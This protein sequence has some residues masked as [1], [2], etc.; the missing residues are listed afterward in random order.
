MPSSPDVVLFLATRCLYRGMWGKGVH[1]TKHQPDPQTDQ[2]SWWPAVVP[3]LT[4]RCLH[5]GWGWRVSGG[6]WG[7]RSIRGIGGLDMKNADGLLQSTLENSRW[8]IA[9]NRT[10]AQV[11]GT[12]VHTTLGHLMPLP[13]DIAGAYG[14]D[15]GMGYIWQNISLT[16]RLMRCHPD[17]P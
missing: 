8:S 11:N 5:C 7:C 15:G 10:W 9:V 12:Q 1:L 16:Y 17:L 2:T 4:T 6:W 3:H 13:G 14:G